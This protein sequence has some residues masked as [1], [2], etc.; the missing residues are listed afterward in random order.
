MAYT[1]LYRE[2]RPSTF[3]DVV[4]QEHITTTLKNQILNNSTYSNILLGVS[5]V[6]ILLAIKCIFFNSSSKDSVKS[7]NGVLL[8]NDNGK[9]IV[10]KKSHGGF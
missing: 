1:A 9:L 6:F 10:N 3:Y 5:V 4:G 7:G 2:W 8:E